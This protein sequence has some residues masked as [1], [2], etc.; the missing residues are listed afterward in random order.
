MSLAAGTTS[1]VLALDVVT[2]I[3]LG[4]VVIDITQHGVPRGYFSHRNYL[5]TLLINIDQLVASYSMEASKCHDCSREYGQEHGFPDMLI[6]DWAWKII[7]PLDGYGLLCPS[8]IC[9][10]L[11][12]A[13]VENCPSAFTSGPLCFNIRDWMRPPKEHMLTTRD[14]E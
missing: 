9:K 10:R 12:D 1:N 3:A 6:P 8:C 13:N 2:G 5:F 7:A 11:Y 4:I 14:P